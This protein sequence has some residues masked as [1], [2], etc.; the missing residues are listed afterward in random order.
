L[1][2]LAARRCLCGVKIYNQVMSVK[3]S[4]LAIW[5]IPFL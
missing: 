4:T 3:A 2:D 1:V 5:I